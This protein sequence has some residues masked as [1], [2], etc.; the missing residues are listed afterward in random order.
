[1]LLLLVA[2]CPLLPPPAHLPPPLFLM[3]IPGMEEQKVTDVHSTCCSPLWPPLL[4]HPPPPNPT[5]TSLDF[6]Q[7][8][9][10]PLTAPP[11]TFLLSTSLPSQLFLLAP[12]SFA[13]FILLLSSISLFDWFPP[14]RNMRHIDSVLWCYTFPTTLT[15]THAR[16]PIG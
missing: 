15:P 13:S 9:S 5:P 4:L 3:G 1:M 7:T 16:K 8:N 2:L 14:T 12:P 6:L 10:L 11:A